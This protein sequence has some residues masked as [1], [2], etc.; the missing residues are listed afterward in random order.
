MQLCCMTKESWGDENLYQETS[1]VEL[2]RE[3]T[4]A[5]KNEIVTF[6]NTMDGIVLV[7]VEDNDIIS[8]YKMYY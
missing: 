3:L 2:K 4:D 8:L 1:N 7:G 5:V 6:L